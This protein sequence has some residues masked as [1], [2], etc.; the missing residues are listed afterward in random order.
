MKTHIGYSLSPLA[1]KYIEYERTISMVRD[2]ERTCSPHI[3]ERLLAKHQLPVSPEILDFEKNLGGWCSSHAFSAHGFG[4]YLSLQEGASCSAVANEWRS[5]VGLFDGKREE[6]DEDGE[7][8]ALWGT[9]Y[10]RAF[11][12]DRIL[13]PAG[14]LGEDNFFFIGI[15]GEVYDWIPMLDKLLLSAGNGKTLIENTALRIQRQRNNWFEVHVCANV[16]ELAQQL[17]ALP[18]YEPA[19]DHLFTWWANDTAQVC[20]LPDYAPCV[21]G[22]MIACQNEAD[23]RAVIMQIKESLN[24]PR[25][26]I[27]RDANLINDWYGVDALRRA[28]ILC[29]ELY[30]PG[31]GHC[32]S[33]YETKLFDPKNWK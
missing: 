23:L 25:I 30:G 29:E 24:V 1:H 6:R 4:V 27:W 18:L 10:P 11:F 17:L 15:N 21:Q 9:G 14:M 12:Q 8:S 22:T 33:I 20:L 3:L 19:C 31:P 5:S 13:I 16:S 28:G 32:G 7:Y 26:R 2:P